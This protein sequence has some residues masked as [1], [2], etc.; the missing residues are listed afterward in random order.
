MNHGWKKK[1]E[2]LKLTAKRLKTML[3]YIHMICWKY[4]P[5]SNLSQ[6]AF[7]SSHDMFN[8]ADVQQPTACVRVFTRLLSL[9]LNWLHHKDGNTCT[10][11]E[12]FVSPSCRHTCLR[13][14]AGC[15]ASSE[16]NFRHQLNMQTQ[17]LLCFCHVVLLSVIKFT[18][19]LWKRII[20]GLV[21]WEHVALFSWAL[22]IAQSSS[23]VTWREW[24]GTSRSRGLRVSY[25][26]AVL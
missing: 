16:R 12:C 22:D 17:L 14:M 7:A 25:H 3:S 26:S 20:C 18:S 9:S 4:S 2:T 8:K 13:H 10:S 24:V 5:N 11:A 23:F 19:T 1:K 15:P 21:T 6:K